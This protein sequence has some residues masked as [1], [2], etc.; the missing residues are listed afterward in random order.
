MQRAQQARWIAR[1]ALIAKCYGNHLEAAKLF[2]DALTEAPTDCLA[3]YEMESS[4][5]THGKQCVDRGLLDRA[6]RI[7]LEAA[8]VNPRSVAALAS[9][10][11]LGEA[12]SN[13]VEA[14]ILWQRIL[15]L[16]PR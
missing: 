4:L 13:Y 10:A 5:I 14:E 15:S 12:A 6:H 2:R 1:Q 9:L 8:S 7:F 3:K 16:D 11:T